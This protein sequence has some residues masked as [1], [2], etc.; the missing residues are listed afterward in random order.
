MI[1]ITRKR[2]GAAAPARPLTLAD[3]NVGLA[4][5]WISLGLGAGLVV[6][7][8]GRRSWG[9]LALALAGGALLYR[10]ASGQCPLYRAAG[11]RT[12][13]QEHRP[14]TETK[15]RRE[16]D[17]DVVDKASRESFPAS[18]APPWTP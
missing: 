16:P 12:T 13:A 1:A 18:D 2:E 6:A 7:G 9:G 17:E 14:A 5:R 4:E 11:I 8:L 10:G 3:I 15:T